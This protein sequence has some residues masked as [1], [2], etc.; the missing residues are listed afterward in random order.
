MRTHTGHKGHRKMNFRAASFVYLRMPKPL[1]ATALTLCLIG[2]ESSTASAD[3]VECVIQGSPIIAKGVTIYSDKDS[4][5]ALAQF[6]SQQTP[7]RLSGFGETPSQQR[8]QV[9]TGPGGLRMEGWMDLAQV[10]FSANENIAVVAGHVW[11]GKGMN[12]QLKSWTGTKM[13]V[14][15]TITA[16]QQVLSGEATCSQIEAGHAA[17]P[18]VDI[19]KSTQR[20][21]LK[22]TT[23]D[24]FDSANGSSIFS[25]TIPTPESGVLLY[26]NE[27]S[28]GFVHIHHDVGVVLDAWVRLSDV[29][30]FPKTEMLDSLGPITAASISPAALK[31]DGMPKNVTA[32]KDIAVRLAANDKAKTIGVFESG[33][34]MIVI[35]TIAGWARVMPKKLEIIPPDGMDYWVKA[36]DI[37]M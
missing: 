19:D 18:E 28:G 37:G 4:G 13:K 6:T 14:E 11:I 31:I 32:T 2:L 36:A 17:V 35:D 30:A 16:T 22:K 23:T 24:I 21:V 25:L 8:A 12:L 20:W 29:K 34:E 26:S 10:S 3:T 15:T 27:K 5:T 7:V 9:K 1:I 33:A